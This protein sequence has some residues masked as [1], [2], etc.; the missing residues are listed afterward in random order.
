[1][2]IFR[3]SFVQSLLALLSVHAGTLLGGTL[4]P[5][6]MARIVGAE[7]LGIFTTASS[8][9]LLLLA[10]ID[11]GYETRL[12]LLI[13]Q[14]PDSLYKHIITAQGAKLR[15]WLF[16]MAISGVGYGIVSL[17][18]QNSA[19]PLQSA[20]HIILP[21]VLYSVWALVRGLASTYS[22]ALRG[23]QQFGTIARV[24]NSLT[25]ASHLLAVSILMLSFVRSQTLSPVL[26]VS[27]VIACL[28]A[29]EIAKS[30][31]FLGY[32]R[33]NYHRDSVPALRGNI[34]FSIEHLMFVT[35]QALGIVQSRAGIYTLTLLATQTEVGYFSAVIRFTIA[36]RIL[37]GA[38]FTVLLPRFVRSQD[39]ETLGKALL[40]GALIG[41]FGSVALYAAADGLIW[42][43]Y[44]ERFAHLVP[45]LRLV[46]WLFLLQT[47]LN[48]L[49]PYLLAHKAERFVNGTLALSLCAFAG[50]C[51]LLPVNTARMAAV[52][53]LGLECVLVVIYGIKSLTLLPQKNPPDT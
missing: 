32:L 53:S 49:E 19:T 27:A 21:L 24:E 45:I 40:A 11:W 9:G 38:L 22:H 17:L 35:M 20:V 37:P 52:M 2:K 33:Q 8:F 5:I 10:V 34:P 16:A 41:T 13:S 4:L 15:L 39:S 51:V 30:L 46:A 50:I 6:A 18:G 43:V 14:T 25:L 31:V 26:V 28:I 12:P 44:G 23:L 36:L 7:A 48:I 1:V 47:L 29:S 3:S 42:L